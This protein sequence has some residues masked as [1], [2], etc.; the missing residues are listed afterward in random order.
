MLIRFLPDGSHI[1]FVLI[2]LTL[3]FVTG[4]QIK[5]SIQTKKKKNCNESYIAFAKYSKKIA[6]IANE[7]KPINT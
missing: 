2:H 1:V 5:Q 6:K 7:I 3:K 4:I